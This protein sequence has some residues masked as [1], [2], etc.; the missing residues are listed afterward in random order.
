LSLPVPVAVFASGGG[1]NL[2]SLLDHQ[3]ALG[4]ACGYRVAIV[5][6]D[7]ESAGALDR[8]RAA[9]CEVRVVSFKDRGLPEVGVE[10]LKALQTVDAEAILLAGFLKMIP[11][12]VIEAFPSRILNVHPALLPAFGGRGMYGRHVHE[13]VLRSGASVSGPTVHFVDA[14]YDTGAIIAQWPVPVHREDTPTVLASRVLTAEHRLY[15]AVAHQLGL[16]IGTGVEMPKFAPPVDAFIGGPWDAQGLG[17]A[18]Q[19]GFSDA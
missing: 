2:Q 3:T 1:S 10:V 13:A 16:A 12:N 7:R 14:Q 5:V 6:A 4:D 9:G 8:G 11:A 17:D 18:I 15:P 19:R